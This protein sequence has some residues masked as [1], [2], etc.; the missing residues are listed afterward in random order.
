MIFLDDRRSKI[1]FL[2]IVTKDVHINSC[3]HYCSGRQTTHEHYM[4]LQGE[5]RG[6][7]QPMFSLNCLCTDRELA[8]SYANTDTS[9][10][11]IVR[12]YQIKRL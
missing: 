6:Q 10:Q 12:V 11:S 8:Q 2:F 3:G 5:F 4:I 1:S 9:G 7:Y